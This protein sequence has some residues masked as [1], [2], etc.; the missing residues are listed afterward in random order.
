MLIS[1]EIVSAQK[2][3]IEYR[4]NR[5]SDCIIGSR[6]SILLDEAD[7][8]I[9]GITSNSPLVDI[10]T[11][12]T[13][14]DNST[15]GTPYNVDRVVTT[16]REY[17]YVRKYS[18]GTY[19][20]CDGQDSSEPYFVTGF[21]CTT[22]L[23]GFQFRGV[24]WLRRIVFKI[25]PPSNYNGGQESLNLLECE[26]LTVGFAPCAS[27][28]GVDYKLGSGSWTQLLN[29]SYRSSSI[30]IDFSSIP[31]LQSNQVFQ[32][33]ARYNNSGSPDFSDTITVNTLKCAPQIT[34]IQVQDLDC[35]YSTDGSFILTFDRTLETGERLANLQ[36][37]TPGPNNNFEPSSDTSSDD[38]LTNLIPNYFEYTGTQYSFPEQLS[39]GKY[40][41]KYQSE[42]PA[43][44][45]ITASQETND[46]IITAP[47]ALEYSVQ[48]ESE[49]TCNDAD[50]GKIRLTINP[51]NNG[52]IGTPP[53]NYVLGNGDTG[54]FSGASTTVSGLSAGSTTVQVFDSNACTERQ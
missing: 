4:G 54:T 42:F 40:R 38:V 31:G 7:I 20:S 44:N 1:L 27:S 15:P 23:T 8:Q 14:F 50:D 16:P 11:I 13:V 26:P 51:N 22:A 52:S 49:I 35:S 19:D 34:N 5:N 29:Y 3:K 17:V 21:Q 43:N 41:F 32:L 28:Y 33:R 36:Y 24:N 6:Y 9:T 39:A 37:E 48:I 12:L 53:Y 47:P 10:E 45:I 18:G 25:E 46:I 30:N 2:Y